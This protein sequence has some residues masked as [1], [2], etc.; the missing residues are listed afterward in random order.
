MKKAIIYLAIGLM[1]GLSTSAFAAVSDTVQAVY[2]K[3]NYVVNGVAQPPSVTALVYDGTSYLRTTDLA[4]ML[5]YDVV[6]R[7]DSRTIEFNNPSAT[8]APSIVPVPTTDI[9]VTPTPTP[10]P[11]ATPAP[12]TSPDPNATPSPMPSPTP[13]AAP[14]ATPTPTPT[15]SV[16]PTPAPALPTQY[17][18]DPNG[19]ALY[20]QSLP[21]DSM[22]YILAGCN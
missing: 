5:G 4:N 14:S 20:C 13:T 21:K 10:D 6:Y 19:N 7:A 8:P 9:S 11:N 12:T 17:Q 3:F 16:A 1:L 15:P 22:T 2:A 18:N